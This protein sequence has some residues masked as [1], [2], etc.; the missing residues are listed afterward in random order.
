MHSGIF[1]KTCQAAMIPE[2]TIYHYT[3]PLILNLAGAL[4]RWGFKL[5]M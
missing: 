5:V 1:E 4:L 2:S 3:T